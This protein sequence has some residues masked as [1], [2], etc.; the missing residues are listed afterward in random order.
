MIAELI[1]LFAV[2][3]LQQRGSRIAPLVA[4]DLI[5]LVELA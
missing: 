3:Y 5:D 2:Q 4:A 1:V